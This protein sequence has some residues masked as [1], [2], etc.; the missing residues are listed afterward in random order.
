MGSSWCSARALGGEWLDR[1]LGEWRDVTLEISGED[2]IAAGVPEGP[3]VGRGLAAA[4]RAKLDGEAPT[5]DDELRIALEAAAL[6]SLIRRWN[7]AND[8]GVRWLEA[9][10]P[11]A[12]AA[13]STRLGGASTGR[14]S[15]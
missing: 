12:R 5:R 9:E 4:L 13:F 10:L 1:Y 11:G 8:D 2:L 6:L 7:G 3:A 14:S 15:R